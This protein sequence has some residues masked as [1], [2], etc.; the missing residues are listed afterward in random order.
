MITTHELNLTLE[1]HAKAKTEISFLLE[2]FADTI[3]ELMGG[4]TATV[5]RLAGCH[6]AEK[7]P[8]YLPHPTLDNVLA[9]V[10]EHLSSGYDIEVRRDEEGASLTFGRCAIRDILTERKIPVGG[11]LCK[12]FHYTVAGM[13]NQL[14]GKGAKGSIVTPGGDRCLTRVDV[15]DN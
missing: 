7:L 4:A 12:V 15:N 1:D 9:A 2:I 11:D 14:L 5:G 10:T 3:V 6:M 13:V 8:V